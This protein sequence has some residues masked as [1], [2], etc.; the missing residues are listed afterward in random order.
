MINPFSSNQSQ[1]LL[2]RKNYQL[3]AKPEPAPPPPTVHRSAP[4]VDL[5]TLKNPFLS[6][7]PAALHPT[8]IPQPA[9]NQ[10]RSL[11]S[12]RAGL[13]SGFSSHNGFYSNRMSGEGAWKRELEDEERKRASVY[14]AEGL[15]YNA[16]SSYGGGYDDYRKSQAQVKPSFS[17]EG[18]SNEYYM[19]AGNA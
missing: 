1:N 8:H 3:L 9:L 6:P 19:G 14:G 13:T 16:Y 11:S 18:V 17:R 5:G 10:S 7:T 2:F 15:R 4:K 12:S